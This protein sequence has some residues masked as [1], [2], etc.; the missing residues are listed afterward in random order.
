ML[1][2]TEQWKIWFGGDTPS[3]VQHMLRKQL[4]LLVGTFIIFVV[5]L[6]LKKKPSQ[7]YLSMGDLNARSKTS[8]MVGCSR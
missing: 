4:L 5:L 8:K 7:F 2:A 6:L 1:R 3:F